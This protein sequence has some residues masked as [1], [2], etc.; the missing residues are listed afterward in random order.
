MTQFAQNNLLFINKFL[1]YPKKGRVAQNCSNLTKTINVP[2]RKKT[3]KLGLADAGKKYKCSV[4]KSHL[5]ITL[6][7]TIF[8]RN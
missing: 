8:S 3:V 6:E 1:I 5:S 7:R 2:R 4:L